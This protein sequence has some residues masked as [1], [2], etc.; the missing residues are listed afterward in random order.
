[1]DKTA[2]PS[3]G[4]NKSNENVRAG[5]R[6]SE[7]DRL[8]LAKQGALEG[9]RRGE[10]REGGGGRKRGRGARTRGRVKEAESMTQTACYERKGTTILVSETH[11]YLP[12]AD[13]GL[14]PLKKKGA[15][16]RE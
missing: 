2:K 15:D 14:P 5:E 1:M 13:A 6:E 3:K 4:E 16:A 12:A 8:K 11:V 9:V 7:S 10:G